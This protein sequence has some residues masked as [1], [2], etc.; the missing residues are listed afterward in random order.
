MSEA[1]TVKPE[2][3]Y[4]TTWKYNAALILEELETIVKNNG[5]AICSTWQ[6]KNAPVWLTTR[7]SF[8]ITNR[9]LDG[10]KR[11]TEERIEKLK[12]LKRE[13]AAAG[14]IKQL[15][16]YNKI[17]NVPRLSYY[18]NY[19]YICFVLDG[20]YYY[21]S[22]DEN[23]FFDFH[24]AK[25]KIEEENKIKRFYYCFDDKKEWLFDCFFRVNCSSEDR[26]EAANLI[27]NKLQN[28]KTCQTYK[29]NSKPEYLNIFLM[30]D[31][32]K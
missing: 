8:L 18:G 3:R 12:K 25:M 32:Q 1:T 16:E 22:M 26:R 11:E 27:F 2:R 5:G 7:K 15:E 30:E 29:S 23:P 28:S 19:L 20:Y 9:T 17:N 14:F 21:F 4:L 24:F 10:A 13:E 6:G 31:D